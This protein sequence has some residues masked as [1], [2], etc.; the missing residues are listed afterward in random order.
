M[1]RS[2]VEFLPSALQSLGKPVILY[3]VSQD[4]KHIITSVEASRIRPDSI[5]CATTE[6]VVWLDRNQ[7]LVP[8]I[9]WRHDREFDPTLETHTLLIGSRMYAYFLAATFDTFQSNAPSDPVTLLSSRCTSLVTVYDIQREEDDD[10]SSGSPYSL[11]TSKLFESSFYRRAGLALI[12]APRSSSPPIYPQTTWLLEASPS[13]SL[14]ITPF[15]IGGIPY[16][17]PDAPNLWSNFEF[18]RLMEQSRSEL[19][20]RADRQKIHMDLR[21]HLLC[22]L[23]RHR[24]VLLLT[25][26]LSLVS[27]RCRGCRER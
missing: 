10:I 7:P 17:P 4:N 6:H 23:G 20:P 15:V 26:V 5:L 1:L 13:H 12:P 16:V 19:G 18:S 14:F 24:L 8:L 11:S 25:I 22:E 3:C 27:S 21:R 2:S 9:S